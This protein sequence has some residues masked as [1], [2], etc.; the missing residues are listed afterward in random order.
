MKFGLPSDEFR[1]MVTRLAALGFNV[2]LISEMTGLSPARIWFWFRDELRKAPLEYDA[3]VIE[4]VYYRAVGGRNPQTRDPMRASD[5]AQRAWL[6]RRQGW[7]DPPIVSQS[8]RDKQIAALKLD[9]E[10]LN[11]DDLATLERTLSRVNGVLQDPS[12]LSSP[13]IEGDVVADE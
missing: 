9:L 8:Q 1:M 11:D 7:G 4:A 5:A 13:V 6:Q 10:K 12:R 3:N 2:P